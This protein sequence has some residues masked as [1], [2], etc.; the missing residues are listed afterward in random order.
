MDELT[1]N[2]RRWK[3]HWV[4]ANDADQTLADYAKVHDLNVTKL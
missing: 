1:E 2:E 3:A 4:A